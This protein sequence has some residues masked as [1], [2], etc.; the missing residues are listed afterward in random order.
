VLAVPA[1]FLTLGYSG[2]WTNALACGA[3]CLAGIA[4]T[5]D[6]D[7][8]GLSSS[9]Y[10]IIKWTLGLGF[11]WTMLWY[12]YAR[13]CKH[14]SVISHFPFIG[15]AG[16]LAYLSILPL[17][18]Y[19]F[20]SWQPP[21]IPQTPFLLAITGLMASDIAHWAMDTRLGDRSSRRRAR[22]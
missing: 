15:T 12:P 9:E 4:I 11:L 3:G 8:E 13:L 18:A 17:L 2:N 6:L 21:R 10:W 14:R 5:P 19:Y 20:L 1:C 22:R 7:Q 16:R